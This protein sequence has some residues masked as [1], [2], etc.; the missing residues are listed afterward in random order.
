MSRYLWDELGVEMGMCVGVDVLWVA[1][2]VSCYW[3]VEDE[4]VDGL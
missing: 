2:C 3:W 1:R 4:G